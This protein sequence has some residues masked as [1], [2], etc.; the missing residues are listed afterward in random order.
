MAYTNM[1]LS[2]EIVSYVSIVWELINT[3]CLLDAFH[4]SGSLLQHVEL[5]LKLLSDL[6]MPWMKLFDFI[7]INEAHGINLTLNLKE[8][9]GFLK[10]KSQI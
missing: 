2:T 8:I 5:A 1:S 6:F 3:Y 9:S 4:L 10:T 7:S